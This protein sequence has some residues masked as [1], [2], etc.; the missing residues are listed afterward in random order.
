MI[1]LIFGESL[2]MIQSLAKPSLLNQNQSSAL[3]TS[4][5]APLNLKTSNPVKFG[6]TQGDELNSNNPYSAYH[7]TGSGTSDYSLSSPEAPSSS[8][9]KTG[10]VKRTLQVGTI[11]A[12]LLG[13][14]HV[15]AH[16]I[17]INP[18]GTDS[19]VLYPDDTMQLCG[20]GPILTIP[21][22]STVNIPISTESDH[23]AQQISARSQDG[24]EIKMDL[25]VD[26]RLNKLLSDTDYN[27]LLMGLNAKEIRAKFEDSASNFKIPAPQ[28]LYKQIILPDII[29]D[30][31]LLTSLKSGG[32]KEE[33]LK[34]VT[35]GLLNGHD[36]NG[37][38][39]IPIKERFNNQD[40]TL[41]S[42]Q[43][44]E[45]TTK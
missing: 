26:F 10:L 23:Y 33:V 21:P 8:Q 42:V 38:T 3:N 13:L 22:Y 34:F 40:M 12:G 41:A 5:K 14:G 7:E 39:V 29:N 35:S 32:N 20:S 30:V 9:N 18:L 37:V 15:A 25:D 43:L 11:L 45:S 24:V 4:L 6:A 28:L 2:I 44:K 16:S 17:A 1:P 36:D 19:V 31:R 27:Q